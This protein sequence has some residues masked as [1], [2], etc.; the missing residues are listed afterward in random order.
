MLIRCVDLSEKHH[1]RFI[2]LH[3]VILL[4]QVLNELNQ[5]S[6]AYRI[7]TSVMPCVSSLS[8]HSLMV[9]IIELNDISLEAESYLCLSESLLSM[10]PGETNVTNARL[11][12]DTAREGMICSLVFD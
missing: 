7:L 9:Q 12:L 8:V 10:S 3:A 6:E 5:C 2:Y 4:A 1:A 11:F